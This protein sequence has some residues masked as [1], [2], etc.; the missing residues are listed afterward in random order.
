MSTKCMDSAWRN[1]TLGGKVRFFSKTAHQLKLKWWLF[2]LLLY[3]IKPQLPKL[4]ACSI[5][6]WKWL[7]FSLL[8]YSFFFLQKVHASCA[9]FY[10]SMGC[11]P[12]QRS[13]D[14]CTSRASKTSPKCLKVPS[15]PTNYPKSKFLH[16]KT[17]QP[18]KCDQ[19]RKKNWSSPFHSFHSHRS[20]SFC[21]VV[22]IRLNV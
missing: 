10:S 17:V 6:E 16:L 5:I 8:I 13:W 19:K 9:I 14:L 3:S 7:I 21:S 15:G 22:Y 18:I 2:L 4:P 12:K 20:A 11:V 1:Q